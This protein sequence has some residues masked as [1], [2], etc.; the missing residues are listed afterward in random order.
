MTLDNRQ[1]PK[2]FLIGEETDLSIEVIILLIFG[3]FMLLFGMLLFGI[4]TGAL[5]Y[6]PDS[7]YG[8]FLVIVSFQ[9]I[10]M[11]KTPFGDLSR[12][13]ALIII[14]ICT[15]ILGM[16]A[17]FI[18]GYLSEL[19]RMLV[20]IILSIGGIALLVQLFTSKEKA[21]TWM[22]VPGILQ[23]LTIA[24]GLVYVITVILGVI[25]LLP[26]ITTDPQTAMILII[27]GISFL[28]LSW[29]IHSVSRIYPP[30]KP[31]NLALNKSNL[32]NKSK[33]IFSL[34]N[35]ASLNLAP[36]ILLV[37]AILL[38]LLGII[39]F[40]V[41][42][43]IIPYSPDGE[44][45][46]LLFIYAIQIMALGETPIGQY[47]RSRLLIIIGL[48]FATLGIF[49][50]IVPGILTGVIQILIGLLSIMGGVI[51]LIKRFLIQPNK[52]ESSPNEKVTVPPIVKKLIV[53]QT[54][55]NIV[56]IVFGVSAIAGGLLPGRVVAGLLVIYGLILLLL[57][58]ILQKINQMEMSG[59]QPTENPA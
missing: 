13:W 19:V 24:C 45:G 54:L 34:F 36:A 3:V 11:G 37:L 20:G 59:E 44:F 31:I 40:P 25:T 46:L 2:T 43:G 27:Y 1:K 39:L 56:A 17:C 6:A 48:V 33:G 7:T 55:M 49:S 50:C 21:K 14:G 47:K 28:Y 18:P 9:I 29:C 58:F 4:H 53:T 12:S 41:F 51:L 32:N 52:T 5:P 30:E 42:M 23:Q 35:E 22:K 8:L 57:V 16:A 15:A 26:G 10:T 38:T